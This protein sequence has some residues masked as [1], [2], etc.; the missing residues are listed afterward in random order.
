MVQRYLCWDKK[1]IS[2][3]RGLTVIQHRPEKKNIALKC[4]DVWEG[5]HNGYATVIQIGEGYRLYYRAAGQNGFVFRKDGVHSESVICV[6]ESIDGIT[7]TKPVVGKIEYEGSKEN[8]IVFRRNNG[9]NLDTFTVFYDTNPDCPEVEKFKALARDSNTDFMDLYLS[10]DGYGFEYAQRIDLKGTFDTYN[11]VFWDDYKKEYHMYFRGFHHPDGRDAEGMRDVNP[12]TDIRD[13][14]LGISKDLRNWEYVDRIKLENGKEVQLYTNQILPYYREKNTLIGFPVRY[15]DREENG[16]SLKYLPLSEKRKALTEKYGRSC[17]AFTDCGIMTSGDGLDF[18]LRPT[19]FLTPGQENSSNWWYGDCYTVYGITETLAE[20]SENR[21][22]SMYVG[23]NY[24]VK[25]VDFRRMTLRL[26]G[27]FS[28]YGDENGAEILV[29]PFKYEGGRLA[30]NFS[31]SA[32]GGMRITVT[33]RDGKPVE[34]YNSEVI[35]GDSTDRPVDFE[36]D[37]RNLSGKEIRLRIKLYDC[38]LYSYC[39]E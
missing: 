23:E 2:E 37:L 11:T 3:S 32:M 20:D 29:D 13:I 38:H 25:N 15:R 24:R 19:A 30:V 33:D 9:R 1:N 5:V 6:A 17:T 21:E 26:D 16:E 39:F 10:S 27:F 4:G 22:I 35:F 18:N 28:W 12:K 8:N 36:K 31:S 7:F 34:G 14:R